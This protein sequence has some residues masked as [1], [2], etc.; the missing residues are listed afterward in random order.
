[1]SQTYQSPERHS[2][3]ELYSSSPKHGKK[4]P[5]RWK[6]FTVAAVSVVLVAA[7]AFAG[8]SYYQKQ[9]EERNRTELLQSQTYYPGTVVEGMD[10]GGKTKEDALK[11]VQ[12]KEAGLLPKIDIQLTYG[13]KKWPVTAQD[14]GIK[15]NTEQVLDEAYAYARTGT[16]EER[17]AQIEALKT[18]PKTY[19]LT[20]TRDDS[21]LTQKLAE[22]AKAI[23]VAPV[24]ATVASFDSSTATFR[25]ADGKNGISVDSDALLSKVNALVNDTGTGTIEIPVKTVAFSVDE[26]HLKS[27]MQKLGS[28]TTT[29][30]NTA[31]GNHNMKLGASSI[32][33]KVIQPGAVFSFNAAT[34]DSNLPENGYR[35]AV[36]IS[37]GKKVMEYGGGICQVSSTL[38]GAVLRSNMEI[39]SRANHMWRSSYVPVGL[40]A[41]VSYPYLDFK[42]KNP[43]EYP[44]YIVA[45]MS[46]TKVTVTLYGYQSPDYDNIEISSWQT[47]TVEQPAD[48]LV[49]DSSLK[50]GEKVLDRKGNAGIRAAAKRTFYL[51]G[52]VVKTETLPSSYYRAIATIYKVGPGTKE[53]SSSAASSKPSSQ[54]PAS[55]APSSSAASSHAETPSAHSESSALVSERAG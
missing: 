28:Y 17:L 53:N 46:G 14:L 49:E 42:F 20:Q 41:T 18:A 48:Q 13:D 23:D 3:T 15:F 51:N 8:F 36:A 7:A 4:T 34:G 29:S 5:G 21:V 22:I 37:G 32:N 38:Y 24:N 52:K 50:K 35:K 45:G 54:A 27:H 26:A 2:S 9:A 12:G 33:G 19:T 31:D 6:R 11:A 39:T 10:L 30:T 1:M 16:D 47:G 55:S 44:V 43:T 40:D 25:Y